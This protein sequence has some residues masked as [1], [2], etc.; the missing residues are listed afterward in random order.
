MYAAAGR[1]FQEQRISQ[2]CGGQEVIEGGYL[3]L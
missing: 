1:L 3:S 2:V